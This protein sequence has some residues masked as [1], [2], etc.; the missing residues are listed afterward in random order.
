MVNPRG[1]SIKS[2]DGHGLLRVVELYV[3]GGAE[4][5]IE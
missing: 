5:E 3:G 1:T 4:T 2:W